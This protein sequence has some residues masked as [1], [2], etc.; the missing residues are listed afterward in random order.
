MLCVCQIVKVIVSLLGSKILRSSCPPAT[1]NALLYVAEL[2]ASTK[3]HMIPLLPLLMPAVIDVAVDV[4]L[5]ERSDLV[6][7]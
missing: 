7:S 1:A 2:C 4:P 5:L 6:Q 3:L